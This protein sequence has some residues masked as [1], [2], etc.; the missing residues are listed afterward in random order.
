MDESSGIVFTDVVK[1]WTHLFK[2]SILNILHMHVNDTSEE[3]SL[4]VRC[5][6]PGEEENTLKDDYS[7][8]T[9]DLDA[10]GRPL[11]FKILVHNMKI[12]AVLYNTGNS[13]EKLKFQEIRISNGPEDYFMIEGDNELEFQF[14]KITQIPLAMLSTTNKQHIESLA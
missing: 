7:N 11:R 6:M 14:G 9:F 4:D 1:L 10:T 3:V 8:E 12:W 13:I 2:P 5:I